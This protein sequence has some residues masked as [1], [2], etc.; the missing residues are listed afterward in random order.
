MRF[1]VTS[2]VIFKFIVDLN[3]SYFMLAEWGNLRAKKGKK[4]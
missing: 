1:Y 3:L 2:G 4:K